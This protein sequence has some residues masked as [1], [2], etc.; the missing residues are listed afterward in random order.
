MPQPPPDRTATTSAEASPAPVR[1][2]IRDLEEMDRRHK[3]AAK[4]HELQSRILRTLLTIVFLAVVAVL[5]TG[6]AELRRPLE[7]AGKNLDHLV[8]LASLEVQMC[9]RYT[10]GDPAARAAL[11][12]LAEAEH[13]LGGASLPERVQGYR[14]YRQLARVVRFRA[15]QLSRGK[16]FRLSAELTAHVEEAEEEISRGQRQFNRDAKTYNLAIQK[17]PGAVV[18]RIVRFPKKLPYLTN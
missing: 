11:A 17:F 5:I 16:R 10:R 18:H 2:R 4:R 14:E 7:T 15:V 6:W 8:S 1:P 13:K 9:R 3:Q 12:K